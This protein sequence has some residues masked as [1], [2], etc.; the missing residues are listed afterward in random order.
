M[1]TAAY[2]WLLAADVRI[3]GVAEDSFAPLG[4]KCHDAVTKVFIE[5][6]LKAFAGLARPRGNVH[7]GV[8]GLAR[9]LPLIFIACCTLDRVLHFRQSSLIE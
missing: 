4:C 8:R 9:G 5:A 2:C 6:E 3:S 1:F 7:T